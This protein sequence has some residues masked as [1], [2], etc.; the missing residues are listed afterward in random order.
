M[1]IVE[2]L[3]IGVIII[4]I[5]IDTTRIALIKSSDKNFISNCNKL[6][7]LWF[8]LRNEKKLKRTVAIPISKIKEI[9]RVAIINIKKKIILNMYLYENLTVKIYN[10]SMDY[11][12][13]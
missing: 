1:I 6:P 10:I 12:I 13:K 5:P 4:S 9:L 2:V 11:L 8:K 3:E 7:S